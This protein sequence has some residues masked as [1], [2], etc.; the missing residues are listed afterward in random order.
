MVVVDALDEA[1]AAFYT[2]HAF[3]RLPEALR[4][5]LPMRI[6]ERILAGRTDVP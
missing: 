4:L 3:I 6:V 2:A 1:A 5:V